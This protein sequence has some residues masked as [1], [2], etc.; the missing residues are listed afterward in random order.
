MTD[1]LEITYTDLDFYYK[2]KDVLFTYDET[3]LYISINVPLHSKHASVF[4]VYRI[5][6]SPIS[7]NS[8]SDTFSQIIN[9]PE[10]YAIS[11]DRTYFIELNTLDL[12]SCNGNL[13]PG[14]AYHTQGP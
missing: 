4:E 12:A 6:S 1:F 10:F 8:T 13:E 11:S 3:H 7:T 14:L 2:A 5:T 9:L